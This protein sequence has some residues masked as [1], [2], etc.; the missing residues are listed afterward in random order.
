[1]APRTLSRPAPA[2]GRR[3]TALTELRRTE[4]ARLDDSGAVYLDHTG[5]AL[6][7]DSLVR[8]H[9]R[10]LR[11][12]IFGNPHSENP[13]SCASTA[14]VER[15]RGA[16]LDFFDA[17]PADY[18][19]C[20]TT[21]ASAAIRLV[22]EAFPFAP[23]SRLV[24]ARDNHNS[25]NGIRAF[26]ARAGARVESL[27]LGGDLRL[28]DPGDILRSA[29]DAP[30]L[31]AFPAQSNFSGVQHP[32]ELVSRARR[33]GFSVL[34]DAAAYAPTHRLSLREVQADFV[35]VSF[36]KMFGYP[37]GV[38]ALVARREALARLHRP[39]FAG[40]TVAFVSSTRPVHVLRD[41]AEAFEDGTPDFLSLGAVPAG[42]DFLDGLGMDAVAAHVAS[43][44]VH[45]LSGLQALRHP[46]GSPLVR[47]YG[48]AG[49]EAR[50]GTV[51]F[52]L[53]DAGGG[54]Q[55]FGQVVQAAGAQGISL[56][57]GCFCN[58]GAAEVALA[59]DPAPVQRCLDALGPGVTA[60]RLEACVEGGFPG[61]VRASLGMSS[62]RDDVERLLGF[63]RDFSP[64]A[65]SMPR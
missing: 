48:P 63:L 26:A 46:S 1:M 57:G 4:F 53:L 47:V 55:P 37:T 16:V 14:W 13:S 9:A 19:V 58:P 54:L 59:I 15:A 32:L 33:A 5:S 45:L 56:R 30:S 65:P 41:G 62:S 35:A 50:G 40:G 49:M 7:P 22:A 39:W 64:G 36:Y 24:L 44:T 2:P 10:M 42:L 18:E 31:L 3:T 51:A 43:L 12:G 6:Y 61:A 23:G 20:F 38:G 34:L 8:R 27:P 11:R 17:A 21:N 28:A 60:A 29:L 25:V 52:N